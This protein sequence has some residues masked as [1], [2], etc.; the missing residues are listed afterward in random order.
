MLKVIPD[1][2]TTQSA[3]FSY[4]AAGKFI[5]GV[6][7]TLKCVS[8]NFNVWEIPIIFL[9]IKP[10]DFTVYYPTKTVGIYSLHWKKYFAPYYSMTHKGYMIKYSALWICSNSVAQ[11]EWPPSAIIQFLT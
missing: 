9:F 6:L 2:M 5:N 10:M 1:G 3:T 8:I 7:Y 4:V 11:C